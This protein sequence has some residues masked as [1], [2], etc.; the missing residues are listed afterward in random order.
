[1]KCKEE[2]FANFLYGLNEKKENKRE[3]EFLFTYEIPNNIVWQ[4]K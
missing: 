3:N 2:D 1:M 4:Q